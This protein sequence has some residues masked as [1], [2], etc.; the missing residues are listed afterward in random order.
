M[1]DTETPIE[2]AVTAAPVVLTTANDQEVTAEPETPEAA[3]TRKRGAAKR[4]DELTRNWRQAER[5][6]DY[7]K[8]QLDAVRQPE[9]QKVA[10]GKPTLEQHG[11]DQEKYLDALADWKIDERA[12]KDSQR[13]A[14]EKQQTERQTKVTGLQKQLQAG[15]VKYEDFQD[16]VTN[17]D[18]PLPTHV[19]EAAMELGDA[20]ADVLYFLGK[21]PEKAAEIANMTERGAAIALGRIE[22]SLAKPVAT[23]SPAP[24]VSRAPPPTPV[25]G[26][27]ASVDKDPEKMSADEWQVWR[28]KQI[29]AERQ[30]LK[31]K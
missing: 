11:F 28:N 2:G 15:A 5:E 12:K 24:Q 14:T 17:P 7:L 31:R 16:V 8:G 27:R 21:N 13:Q 29:A 18:L 6:R 26:N 19:V 3:E 1:S 9:P 22:A 30:A 10:P 4:I 25:V 20:T 23:P